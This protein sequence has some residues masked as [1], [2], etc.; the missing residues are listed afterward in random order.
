MAAIKV[1]SLQEDEAGEGAGGS[2]LEDLL[3][4]HT[5]EQPAQSAAQRQQAHAVPGQRTHF[6]SVRCVRF[7][8]DSFVVQ[9]TPS[10]TDPLCVSR[11]ART[12]AL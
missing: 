6:S 7:V 4:R 5:D 3:G 8:T 10:L 11:E 2:A 9:T 12:T 1:V